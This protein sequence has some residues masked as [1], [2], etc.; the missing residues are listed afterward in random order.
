MNRISKARLMAAYN[1]RSLID[2][3]Y[4]YVGRF[5]YNNQFIVAYRHPAT[6]KRAKVTWNCSSVCLY[7]DRKLVDKAAVI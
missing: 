5:Q 3:G 7:V 6:G 4:L 2:S 1:E